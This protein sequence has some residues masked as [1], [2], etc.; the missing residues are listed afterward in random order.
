MHGVGALRLATAGGLTVFYWCTGWHALWLAVAGRLTM[1]LS[2]AR[3]WRHHGPFRCLLMGGKC[4]KMGMRLESA[5]FPMDTND[6]W[7][8][9]TMK[10]YGSE[11]C[12][13]CREFK[14]LMARR[15][16][17]LE[18]VEITENVANL[19]AFL[20]LRDRE[21]VFAPIRAEG[22]RHSGICPRGRNR[23]AGRR[24]SAQLDWP[25]ADGAGA[26]GLRELRLTRK[27]TDAGEQRRTRMKGNRRRRATAAD[28]GEGQPVRERRRSACASCS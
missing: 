23:H 5:C 17:E 22:H 12:S 4:G 28:A 20:A 21:E 6:L 9:S 10:V 26:G 3:E 2:C 7:R 24:R 15:G 1:F 13:G 25:A 18:F 16:L 19:R 14:A 8:T 11:I 27:A